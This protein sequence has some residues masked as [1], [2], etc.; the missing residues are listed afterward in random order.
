MVIKNVNSKEEERIQVL[1]TKGISLKPRNR[2]R[3]RM[4][5]EMKLIHNPSCRNEYFGKLVIVNDSFSEDNIHVSTEWH[6]SENENF[7]DLQGNS[8]CISERFCTNK[9][10]YSENEN[11]SVSKSMQEDEVL[12]DVKETKVVPELNQIKKS[13]QTYKEHNK[14]LENVNEKLMTANKRLQEDLEEKEIDYQKLLI[15][16]KDILKEKRDIKKQY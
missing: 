3:S 5:E 10:A 2:L 9:Q 6:C 1:N 12:M 8:G 15:I 13:L 16:S 11:G 14:F 4:E 7:I